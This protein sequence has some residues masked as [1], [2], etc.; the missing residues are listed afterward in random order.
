LRNQELAGRRI[1]SRRA[2]E[3]VIGHRQVTDGYLVLLAERHRG[4]LFA[5][6]SRLAAIHR[7]AT[8]MSQGH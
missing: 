7:G 5:L 1:L 2:Q 8:P 4:S 3:P 6:D